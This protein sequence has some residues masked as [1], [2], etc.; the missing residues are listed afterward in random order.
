MW[1]KLYARLLSAMSQRKCNLTYVRSSLI[2][3]HDSIRKNLRG[4]WKSAGDP[5]EV[6]LQVFATKLQLG[7]STLTN[8]TVES[9]EKPGRPALGQIIESGEKD[10]QDRVHFKDNKPTA[11]KR[12]ELKA[13]FPFSSDLKRMTTVYLDKELKSRAAVLI[14][15]AVSDIQSHVKQP[16]TELFLT[17]GKAERILGSSTTY[18]PA[19]EQLPDVTAPLSEE[20]RATFMAKAEELAS[21]GL[22]VIG[23]ASRT[24]PVSEIEGL[25]RED[26]EKDFT[27]RG[28]A[29]IF[30]PPRPE[31]LGAVRSCKQA[32]IVVHM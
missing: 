19:P 21:Q 7:R 5:T 25:S 26:A 32:G 1:L 27:F 4:E 8:D 28:L 10:P 12:F 31:T 3:S 15:G 22:R 30:D 20:I 18:V 17:S 29:G 6:A 9:E 16:M 24:I 13:E 14:K 2:N 23:L 11:P